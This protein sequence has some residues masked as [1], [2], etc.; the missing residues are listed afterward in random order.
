MT[1]VAGL[2]TARGFA[3]G[4]VFVYRGDG[5][6][7]IPEYIVEP[8]REDE[9]LTRLKRAMVDTRRDLENLIAILRERT[10]RADVRVFECHLMILED[11]TLADE[12]VRHVK[13]EHLNAEAAVR[14]TANGARSQFERMNDPYFR[15]RVR[16]LDDVERR[17]LKALTDPKMSECHLR[18]RLIRK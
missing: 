2:A 7:P 9:E 5:E 11:Q 17:V 12:T 18:A 1:T 4:P 3:C 6:I 10:G 16:D 13:E 14:K 8:G 15:E